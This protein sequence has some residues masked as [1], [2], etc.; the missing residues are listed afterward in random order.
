MS[1]LGIFKVEDLDVASL[2]VVMNVVDLDVSVTNA[3]LV[4]EVEGFGKLID[5]DS[6]SLRLNEVGAPIRPGERERRPE[7]PP[8]P[9]SLLRTAAGLSLAPARTRAC[10]CVPIEQYQKRILV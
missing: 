3:E 2:R 9:K 7:S 1:Q 6:S 10:K 5:Q 4:H 8:F